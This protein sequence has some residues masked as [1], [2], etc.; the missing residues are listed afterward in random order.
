M[1][2]STRCERRHVLVLNHF[3]VP[4]AA[5]GGTRHV[6]LFGR[7]E[8]WDATILASNRNLLTRTVA[9]PGEGVRSVWTT[10]Y[11]RGGASRVLNWASYAVTAFAVGLR[12]PTDVVYAS[13]P[14]LLAVLAGWGLSRVKRVPLIVEVRDLWPQVLVDMGQLVPTSVLFR[15]MKRLERFLYRHADAVVVLAQGNRAYVVADGARNDQVVFL[16]NSAE[17]SDF[18]V[19]E[20]RATLRARFGM[21]GFVFLYAGAHGQANGLELVLDAAAELQSTHPDIRFWLVGHGLM[22]PRLVEDARRRGLHNVEFREPVAKND[23]PA[24]L[25]AADVGLH[26]LADV[27]LFSHGVS[28]NKLFD[29]MAAGRPVLTNTPGDVAQLVTTAGAGLAVR[30]HELAVGARALVAMDP[31][32]LASKSAAG[33]SFMEHYRSRTV[34]CRQLE[35][36][37]DRVHPA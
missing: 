17:P 25:A 31:D 10:P 20:N 15:L 30:P 7:L 36:L 13:S 9:A 29:Y 18:D 32:E 3:A 5:P 33:R 27:P 28:P 6:E 26:V 1:R 11:S 37:L 21:Q 8:N 24:L 12:R 35:A 22:K 34:I 16:P 19:Q 2:Q 4:R 23:I 14:H